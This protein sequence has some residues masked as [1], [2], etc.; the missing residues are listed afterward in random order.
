MI[1]LWR[2]ATKCNFACG[3]CAY[4]R[5]LN[6]PR[7]AI[8]AAEVARVVPLFQDVAAKRGET[9][10]LSWLG[11]EPF[12]WEPL[13]GLSQ[14]LGATNTLIQSATTN[15]SRLSSPTVRLHILKYFKELTVSIDGPSALHDQLRGVTGGFAKV[16][17]A[18][19]QLI[20]E[21]DATATTLKIRVNAVMMRRT[22]PHLADLCRTL[23]DW[24]VDE[25]T[26][27]QLGGRDRPEYFPANG[28]RE[29][30][31]ATLQATVPGL[32]AELENRGVS[33]C[34]NGLYL[35]RIAAS[36]R[37]E[38][39][40]ITDCKPGETFYFIDEHGAIAPCGFT[41]DDYGIATTELF[42]SDDVAALPH[43]FREM[44]QT[45][46]STAC[47]DCLSTQIFGKFAG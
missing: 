42:T 15:G 16:E 35:D 47:D 5:R 37:G 7:D 22:V 20:A 39:L 9:F 43:R 23:A 19:R 45:R 17:T 8:D 26:F 27:N 18:L 46:R 11:G 6:I 40:P 34:A 3:F 28:L 30:D 1:L 21:R 2:V 12:L 36:S 13:L 29:Q 24:G 25:I 32:S 31:V 38:T 33:L 4:D 10:H 41:T 44:Q 14:H